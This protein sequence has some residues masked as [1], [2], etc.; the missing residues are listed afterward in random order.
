VG[1]LGLPSST[2][3]PSAD[4]VADS[5]SGRL[6]VERATAAS[7]HLFPDRGGRGG[8][9]GHLLD[10]WGAAH[11]LSHLA[12]VPLKRGDLPLAARYSEEALDLTRRTGDRLAANKALNPLAQGP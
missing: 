11:I 9:S 2:P 1:P 4:E 12:V 8:C 6:Y 7:P 3:S 5:P 10:D